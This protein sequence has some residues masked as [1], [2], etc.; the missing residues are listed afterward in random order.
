MSRRQATRKPVPKLSHEEAIE[1]LV[2]Y[3]FGRLSPMMNAAVEAHVRSC[4]I[5]QRQG[6]D[7]AATEKRQIERHIRHLKPARRRLSKRGRFLIVLLLLLVIG[8]VAVI[9]ISQGG[10]LGQHGATA[11]A[12]STPQNS[13]TATPRALKPTMPFTQSSDGGALAFAPNG[14]SVVGIL[15]QSGVQTVGSWDVTTGK[16]LATYAWGGTSAPVAFAW[17][18]DGNLLAA[19]DGANIGVWNVKTQAS[20]WIVT[21]PGGGNIRIYDSQSGSIVQK[22]DA[23]TTFAN[24]GLIAWGQTGQTPTT[25]SGAKPHVS[26]PG[27]PQV[28]LWQSAGTHL[29]AGSRAGAVTVGYSS[30]AGAAHEALLNW[31]PDGRYLIWSTAGQPVSLT[32]GS[33]TS[34]TPGSGSGVAVPDQ[35]VGATVNALAHSGKGDALEWFSPDGKLLA[36]CDRSTAPSADL[37]IFNRATGQP[38]FVVSGVCGQLSLGSLSWASTGGAFALSVPHAPAAEYLALPAQ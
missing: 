38:V 10:L 13:P 34:A 21:L 16:S 7:H 22:P 30:S 2:E 33:T 1:H 26:V 23:T 36:Q 32:A 37:T 27:D 25:V 35:I 18:P 12:T 17:S 24:G 19:A 4:P 9:R 6:L 20:L 14:K 28:S 5:C 31:S 15:D 29:F 3:E 8:Q 11:S